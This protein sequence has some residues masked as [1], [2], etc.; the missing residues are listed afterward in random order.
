MTVIPLQVAT[1][2]PSTASLPKP[3]LTTPSGL[4]PAGEKFTATLQRADFN[5][6]VAAFFLAAAIV[7]IVCRIFGW[8]AVKVGQPYVMGEVIAGICL[9]PS[10]FGAISANA[11]AWAFPSDI[12]PAFGVVAN[13][14]SDLLHVPGRARGRPRPAE[15]QGRT[16]GSDLQRKRR[17]ADAAGHRRRAAA[18]QARRPGQEVRLVRAVHG[19]CDVD[20]RVPGAREDPVGA[21]DAQPPGRAR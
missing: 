11:Q 5:K 20:H 2:V 19:R 13:L 4:S 7:L 14:G 21:A 16:G 6:T 18:L 10:V 3:A 15:G 12:L 1:P 17:G 8:V 9:G